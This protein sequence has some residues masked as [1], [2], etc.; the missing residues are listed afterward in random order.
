[1]KTFIKL[2]LVGLLLFACSDTDPPRPDTTVFEVRN[3]MMY[4]MT[5]RG[6][7]W[8]A[9]NMLKGP[10]GILKLCAHELPELPQPESWSYDHPA[11]L[12]GDVWVTDEDGNTLYF[13]IEI[14]NP[15]GEL[16]VADS[17]YN[18][19]LWFNGLTDFS[20]GFLFELV[21]GAA[22]GKYTVDIWLKDKAGRETDIYTLYIYYT[23]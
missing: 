12:L 21:D 13:N 5:D 19:R 7:T 1:M 3:V 23:G 17:H 22:E 9:I 11:L 4:E 8:D 10:H 15:D 16:M 20:A 6:C 18:L 2:L 14:Y